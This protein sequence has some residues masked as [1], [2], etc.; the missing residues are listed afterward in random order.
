MI[1]EMLK[2]GMDTDLAEM[3]V[4]IEE[5]VQHEIDRKLERTIKALPEVA[6][7]F[8]GV[9]IVIFVLVVMV[10]IIEVYMGSFLFDAYL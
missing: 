8:V 9:I 4:K 3:I 1:P 2:I 7:A 10:P 6:Y 5:Y